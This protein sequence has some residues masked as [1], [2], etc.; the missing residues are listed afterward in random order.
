LNVPFLEKDE[1]KRF[2]GIW[3]KCKKKWFVYEDDKNLAQILRI[4]Q[5]NKFVKDIKKNI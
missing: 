1:I 2:G 3:D 4:F 5:K